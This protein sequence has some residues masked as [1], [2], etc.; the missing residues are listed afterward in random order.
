MSERP[1]VQEG[2][3]ATPSCRSETL[4]YLTDVLLSNGTGIACARA[5]CPYM[6]Q[7]AFGVRVHQCPAFTV[8]H[9]D[10]VYQYHLTI[11]NRFH[12]VAHDDALLL[13][14]RRNSLASEVNL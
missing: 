4:A 8:E 12:Q 7:R 10:A 9:L 1:R 6:R 3:V 13:P 14:W 2:D 11:A 5:L